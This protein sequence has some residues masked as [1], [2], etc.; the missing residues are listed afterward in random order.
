VI[1]GV[2]LLVEA[3]KEV[4]SQICRRMPSI[5]LFTLGREYAALFQKSWSYRLSTVHISGLWIHFVNSCCFGES[6]RWIQLLYSRCFDAWSLEIQSDWTCVLS[7]TVRKG[8]YDEDENTE[9]HSYCNS[10]VHNCK[11]AKYSGLSSLFRKLLLSK[12]TSISTEISFTYCCNDN[13]TLYYG[14]PFDSPKILVDHVVILP[15]GFTSHIR[16]VLN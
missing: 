3:T 5:S 9:N 10:N 4:W 8:S 11:T 1:S 16:R 6:G 15:P 13:K 2:Y 7:T 12:M 14:F